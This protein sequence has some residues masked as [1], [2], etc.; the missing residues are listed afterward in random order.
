M[1]SCIKNWALSISNKE[2][3]W[4]DCVYLINSYQLGN[5]LMFITYFP[6][7]KPQQFPFL[8]NWIFQKLHM[9]LRWNKLDPNIRSSSNYNLFRNA[10]LKPMGPSERKILNIIDPFWIKTVARLR[11]HFSQLRAQNLIHVVPV[12]LTLK[13]QRT[14]SSAATSI[15][16]A[17]PPLRMI[18]KI[19]TFP[20]LWLVITI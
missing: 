17:E 11:L 15:I 1:I 12:V 14:I 7:W 13:T 5:H 4:G 10:L 18:C 19:F 16:Q 2:N 9:S 20:F 6:K 3:G 8:Q